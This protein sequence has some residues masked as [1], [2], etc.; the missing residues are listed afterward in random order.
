MSTT[1]KFIK[2][3]KFKKAT[4]FTGLPG[5][6]L[7]GKICVDYLLKQLKTQKVAEIYSD[8]FPPSVQTENGIATLIKDEIHYYKH[9]GKDYLFLAGPVQP[10]LDINSAPNEHFEFSRA[11]LYALK[12]KG[13][14]EIYTLA[15]LNIGEQRLT[16]E[17]RV[18]VA[19]TSKKKLE[20]WKKIGAITNRPIGLISGI[21]GLLIGMG[22]EEGIE[23]TCLM[24]ETSSRM[25]YGD[26]GAAQKVL[27]LIIKKYD[28]KIDMTSLTKEAK[29]I[30]KAFQE[31]NKQ[32][33]EREE[34]PTN[35]S[36]VR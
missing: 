19:S 16:K 1:I 18:A 32:L 35:L 33:E 15:G 21:A 9:K 11:I 34:T 6:G 30:E 29:Q 13:L 8:F 2:K 7:V 12:E 17:P 22:K 26:P 23:G 36:Y 27:E 28:F 4:L 25:I 5:I 14:N 24:G 20:E 10:T 3:T 31:L